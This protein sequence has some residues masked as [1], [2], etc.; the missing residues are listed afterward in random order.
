MGCFNI[1]QHKNKMNIYNL[2]RF[3]KTQETVVKNKMNFAEFL[4][5]FSPTGHEMCTHN[6]IYFV[7]IK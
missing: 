2:H 3:I 1:P 4:I 5:F 6:A 7:I